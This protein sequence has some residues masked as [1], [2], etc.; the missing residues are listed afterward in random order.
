M[1]FGFI[2]PETLVNTTTAGN[3]RSPAMAARTNGNYMTVWVSDTGDGSGTAIMG[4]RYNSAGT[5][6]GG[7]FLVNTTT[8]G[9]QDLPDVIAVA[10]APDMF[11]VV[12]QSEEAGGSVIR[13]RRFLADGTAAPLDPTAPAGSPTTD[14]IIS[15][16]FGGTKP[17]A[18]TYGTGRAAFVWEAPSGDGDGTAIVVTRITLS[19]GITTPTVLNVNTA[20][21]Q[22]DPQ[23]GSNSGASLSVVWESRA[24]SGDYIAARIV[25][26]SGF[27]NEFLVGGLGPD[28]DESLPNVTPQGNLA[29]WNSGTSIKM[30]NINSDGTTSP[31]VT[32]NSTPGGVISR[33][34]IDR[35]SSD[36]SN[37]VVYFTQSGDDGSSYSLRAEQVSRNGVSMSPELL[38]PEKFTGTQET[39]SVVQLGNFTF[40]VT[41][42]SEADALGNFEIKQRIISLQFADGDVGDNVFTGT[43]QRDTFR[44][45]QGGN[46]TVNALSGDD[47][48]Y[49][50]AAFTAADTVDGD[51]GFDVLILQGDYSGGITFGTGT[52]SNITEVDSISL[53]PGSLTT[54]GDT[55]NNLY[56]YNLTMLD[57]NVAAGARM[58]VNGSGL[59]VGE[60]FIFNG[61]AETDG[62]FLVFGG[63]G[64]D[65]L[66]GGGMGDTFVFNHEGRFAVGDTV[67]GGGGYDVVYLRGDYAI[68]FNGGLAGSLVNV[69]SVGL[70]SYADTNYAGGGDGEFDYS[71]V[72]NNAMMTAG[73]TIT[74]NGSRLGVNEI[75]QFDGSNET[76]GG[77]FRLWGGA[78]SD[79]LR[80]GS[81]ND[82]LY[83]GNGGDALTG[84][85]G[86]DTFRYQSITESNTGGQDMIQDLTIGDIIDLSSIDAN[87][88][89]AGNQAFTFIGSA[90]FT[91]Q[92]GQLRAVEVIPGSNLWTV[93]GDTDGFGGA[94]FQIS[95]MVADGHIIS[96][97]DFAL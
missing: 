80:G 46:D 51:A 20:G 62:Q 49:F 88:T 21:D 5:K 59:A 95:V 44:L 56:S 3:Q 23:I 13:A 50:G 89:L 39:P 71:I 47:S 24:P 85:G 96:A 52:T 58:K 12:W 79:V 8:A 41:W 65:T 78:A 29:I 82:L 70:L 30:A 97:S 77:S 75:M 60:N 43:P 28:E 40:V 26:A 57:G 22:V 31:A 87:S 38:V 91:N 66:T 54:Y 2:T 25:T 94:D 36:G 27:S 6:V 9:N 86:A 18:G 84:G 37:I 48:I 42:A 61:S 32:L 19:G 53:F 45:Q 11:Y 35:D 16:T 1:G 55:A 81:G 64:I 63:K 15:G 4:Q 72:W 76:D 10:G 67:N 17:S 83:G 93:S 73:Q 74:F 69:E 34:A 7:E 14:A 33:S 92:P 90:A 68:D